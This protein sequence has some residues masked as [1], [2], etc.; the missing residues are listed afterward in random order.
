MMKPGEYRT[1]EELQLKLKKTVALSEQARR[2]LQAGIDLLA[3]AVRVTLGPR[4]C[5][6]GLERQGEPPM[7]T[8]DGVTVAEGIT[9]SQPYQNMGAQFLKQ[10]A[11]ATKEMAGDGSTTTILLAQ[12]IIREGLKNVTAGA[13]PMLFRRGLVKGAAAACAA[14]EGMSQP[15]ETMD[16]LARVATIASSDPE[17]GELIGQVMAKLGEHGFI[18]LQEDQGLGLEVEYAEGMFWKEGYVSSGFVTDRERDEA[19]LEDPYLLITDRRVS[20]AEEVVPI[21]DQL[22]QVGEPRLLVIAEEVMGSALGALVVN[23][24]QDRFHCLAVKPPAYGEMRKAMFRDIAILTGAKL[25]GDELGRP[26]QRATL[27]DLGQVSRVVATPKTTTLAG[28]KGS[29]LQIDARIREL[30][31]LI[32]RAQEKY[33]RDKL[34]RRLARLAGTIATIKIGGLTE[35]QRRERRRRLENALS[36]AR[37]AIEEGVVPGGGVA[38]LNLIP[39]RLGWINTYQALIVPGLCS[40]FGIFL[41]RQFMLTIPTELM[42]SARIDGCSEFGIL[43][44]IMLPLI[45]SAAA[46]LSIFTFVFSW[47]DLFWALLVAKQRAVYPIQLAIYYIQGQYGDYTALL[48]AAGSIAILPP[49]IIFLILQERMVEGVTLTGMKG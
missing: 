29:P 12:A 49:L 46:A 21:M 15:L 25:F 23:Q 16:E 27:G 24:Q 26:L 4:G 38:L 20:R 19:V 13:N 10:A 35:A 30:Q 3:D 42:D 9:L 45:K 8:H 34:Q 11:T 39:A 5:N 6:V 41:M 32:E 48:M 37:G 17:I 18:H 33:D 7:I 1:F 43:W 22:M 28:G 47:H 2:D 44:R 40:S 14:L 31:T 36:A